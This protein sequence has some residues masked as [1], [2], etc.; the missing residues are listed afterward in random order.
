MNKKVIREQLTKVL[1]EASECI[2]D[3]FKSVDDCDGFF[4]IDYIGNG[5]KV[6]L[7]FSASYTKEDDIKI[8]RLRRERDRCNDIDDMIDLDD[9]ILEICLKYHDISFSDI[10]NVVFSAVDDTEQDELGDCMFF[11]YDLDINV[12]DESLTEDE[13]DYQNDE[14]D[15]LIYETVREFNKI[16]KKNK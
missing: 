2:G 12:I 5:F 4:I 14:I 11:G 13:F 15:D 3:I 9:K 8:Y 10:D 6:A 16:N 7:H 1:R